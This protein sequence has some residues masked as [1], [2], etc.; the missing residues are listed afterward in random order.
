MK[1]ISNLSFT[2]IL[3]IG[4]DQIDISF[5]IKVKQALKLL[6]EAEQKINIP[7]ILLS[8]V[9]YHHDTLLLIERAFYKKIISGGA[10]A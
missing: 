4:Q 2:E 1:E 9:S 10:N 3:A 7:L 8:S 5:A 6:F